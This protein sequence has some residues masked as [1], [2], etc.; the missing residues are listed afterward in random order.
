MPVTVRGTDILFNDSTTQSTAAAAFPA[1]ADGIGSLTI[2]LV[3]FTSL[4]QTYTTGTTFAGSALRTQNFSANSNVLRSINTLAFTPQTG[5][6][7]ALSSTSQTVSLSLPGTWRLLT[8]VQNTLQSGFV[9]SQ[10]VAS[11]LFQRIA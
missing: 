8:P 7:D 4:N 1:T 6:T 5:V 9:A 3:A 11:G 2:A 10:F